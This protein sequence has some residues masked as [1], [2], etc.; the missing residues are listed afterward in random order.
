MNMRTSTKT[1]LTITFVSMAI[2]VSL[3]GANEINFDGF[4][5]WM[6]TGTYTFDASD[7]DKLVIVISGEHNFNQSAGGQINSVAYDAQPLIKA[8]DV[9]PKKIDGGG[10]G[11][12]ATDIWYLDNP[13][14]YHTAG[15]ITASV[16]GNGSNYVY[17]AILLS[18]TADGVSSTAAAAGSASVDLTTT[19]PGSI[20]ISNIGMG[21]SGNT[22]DVQNVDPDSPAGVIEV[23]S[24]EAGSSWA[25]HVVARTDVALAGTLTYSF[26]TTKTDVATIAAAFAPYIPDPNLPSVDMGGSWITWSSQPVTLNPTV[27]NNDTQVPQ[28]NLIYSWSAI[29]AEGVAFYPNTNVQS[30]DVVITKP[31]DTGDAAAVELTLAVS[32]EGLGTV[33]QAT[34]IYVF[35][36]ACNASIGSGSVIAGAGDFN[37]SCFTNINDFALL[38]SGWLV[39]YDTTELSMLAESWLDGDVLEAPVITAVTV[40]DV[41]GQ[42][43]S[44]AQSILTNAGFTSSI[45]YDY[46]D[47]V[48]LNYVISQ[49][50]A[51]EAEV[52]DGINVTLTVSKGD[53]PASQ[54]T[55]SQVYLA[56]TH[57]LKPDDPLF[58]LVGNR[59][60]LLKVQVIAPN[61]TPVPTVTADLSLGNDTTTLT[62]DA[63][64]AIQETFEDKLGKVNHRYYDSFTNV[65]PAEWVKPGLHVSVKAGS[66]TVEHDIKVGAP[67]LVKM[68]MFDV[69][70]FGLSGYDYPAG[71]F[72]ELEAKWPVSDFIL[73]RVRNI[74][75]PE[76]VVPAR[77]GAPNVRVSSK[78]D[79]KDQTGLNFDGEQ[80]A[81][82]Q[83]VEALSASGGNF[84]VAMQYITIQG[85]PA[86][87][88]AGGFDGVGAP[89]VGILNHELGHALSLPHWGNNA[90]YPYKGTMYGID[91]QPGVYM[92]THVGPT[93][94]FDLRTLTFIPPTVQVK[95]VAS[96][97]LVGYYKKS[98]MQG[99][100]T[101]DQEVGFLMRHFSDYGVN[102]MQNYLEGKV[103]VLRDGNYYKWN[104][105]EG[106]YTTPVNSSEVRYPV[107]Q[108]VQVISVMAATSLTSMDI[109]MVYTPIGPYSGNL[110]RRFDP[111]VAADRTAA[112]SGF[113]PSGGC[114]FSLRIVQGGQTKIYM[115]AASGVSNGDPL[116][117]SSMKTAA[118]NLPATDGEIT[119]VELLLTPDAEDNGLPA[120]PQV[121][122]TW[123]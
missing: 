69:H 40:P 112:A 76:L 70:Y 49:S 48:P 13:G 29:P 84:D 87:G 108:D 3:A 25:G 113:A 36:D 38:A 100:G 68:N 77:A 51:A 2:M 54:I 27:I 92:G 118:V 64:S 99:G 9:D 30:P 12:T 21:G 66:S 56:Q 78:Q 106:D 37:L 24:L 101:G 4:V 50:P 123:Q 22:A 61:G 98:P 93:W 45:V 119:K 71:T 6:Q 19:V 34:N 58:K 89:S 26:G 82:L 95:T 47:N 67:T 104:A 55:I 75:F 102:K 10:H 41:T 94:A 15:I 91:P 17:T 39:D 97:D 57:V 32:L 8:V 11:D 105:T 114:D 33:E 28:R 59:D 109:N 14:D 72:E 20:V 62:L 53:P 73:E 96:Q 5:S 31:S 90:A 23:D 121:L 85:V 52:P 63:P 117:S 81:A 122:Y 60:T 116:S 86:G 120:N 42:S 111:T 83:W 35:D 107:Q 46:D 18:G 1:L 44:S 80:A 16:S 110:I 43:Q 7:A 65:I 79:Y 115:L 103:A 74:I 88:Q